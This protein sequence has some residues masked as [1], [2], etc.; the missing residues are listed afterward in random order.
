[1][2]YSPNY[3]LVFVDVRFHGSV[4]WGHNIL[5]FLLYGKLVYEMLRYEKAAPCHSVL[6]L[7]CA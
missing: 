4:V 6:A 5:V 2:C 1:M 3:D 7:E